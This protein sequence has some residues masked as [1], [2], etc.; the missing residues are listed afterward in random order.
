MKKHGLAVGLERMG[1]NVYLSLR[2][3]GKLKHEDYEVFV[4]LLEQALQGVSHPQIHVL[5]D[6]TE[7]EGWELRAAWDDL[8]LGLKHG[9][10]FSRI[11][12]VGHKRWQAWLAKVGGWFISGEVRHFENEADAAMW[13]HE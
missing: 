13:L 2:V 3:T 11:A 10:E 4:P 5:V 6:C 7:L 8:K 9:S 1:D 12:I